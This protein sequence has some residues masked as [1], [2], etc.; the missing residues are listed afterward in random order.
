MSKKIN[1]RHYE[2][3]RLVSVHFH[4]C[5]KDLENLCNTLGYRINFHQGDQD[6]PVV[7][8]KKA[9][10]ESFKNYMEVLGYTLVEKPSLEECYD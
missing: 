7:Y 3:L 1:C 10:W 5:N 8:V 4:T 2:N 6:K 9:N